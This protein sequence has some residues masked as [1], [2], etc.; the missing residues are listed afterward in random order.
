M[1][2]YG[3]LKFRQ[4]IDE[5]YPRY[6]AIS[7]KERWKKTEIATIVVQKIKDTGGRFLKKEVIDPKTKKKQKTEKNGANDDAAEGDIDFSRCKNGCYW[8]IMDD[9]VAREK[10]RCIK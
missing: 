2:H 10:I 5:Y 8:S 1:S 4:L 3:N 7:N 6:Q 9:E